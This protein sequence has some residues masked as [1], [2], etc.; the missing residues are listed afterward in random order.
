MSPMYLQS[1]K[2]L[3]STVKE[4]LCDIA[5]YPTNHMTYVPAKFENAPSNSLGEDAFKRTNFFLSLTLSLGLTS[6]EV[7][8][9]TLNI[10]CPIHL[11][12]LKV[13]CRRVEE[14]YLQENTLFDL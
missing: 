1:L 8:P 4:E 12:R 5:Q 6:Y 2:L 9:S 14:M 10:M 7:L 3:C 13:L 11:Q